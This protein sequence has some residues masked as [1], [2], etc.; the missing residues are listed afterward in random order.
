MIGKR[1]FKFFRSLIKL[2]LPILFYILLKLKINRRVINFLEEK[3]YF[4]NN[5]QNFSNIISDILKNK[6]IVALDVGAQGGFNSDNFFQKRY[7]KFFEDILV[8]PIKSEA[9][10]IKNKKYVISK[11]SE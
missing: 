9:S 10:K 1:I 5:S 3:S 6:K 4:S 7:N 2:I 11:G 8:E